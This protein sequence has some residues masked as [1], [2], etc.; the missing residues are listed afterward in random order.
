MVAL[1]VIYTELKKKTW[2]PNS[3]DEYGNKAIDT[4]AKIASE[5]WRV[6]I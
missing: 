2:Q 5:L 1:T 3:F 6:I 4:I